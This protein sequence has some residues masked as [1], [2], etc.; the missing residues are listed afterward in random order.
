MLKAAEMAERKKEK[1]SQYQ[2]WKDKEMLEH[3]TKQ[4]FTTRRLL[5]CTQENSQKE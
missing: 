1:T 3:P 2:I 5:D 4:A